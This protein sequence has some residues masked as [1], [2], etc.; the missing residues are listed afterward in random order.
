MSEY[1]LSNFFSVGALIP[2]FLFLFLFAF[3]L[4]IR[5]KSKSTFHLTFSYVWAILFNLGYFISG[6]F[7]HPDAAFHRWLTVGAILF[8]ETH[9]NMF[10]FNLCEEKYHR[11]GRALLIAQY[12]VAACA[13]AAFYANTI[14]ADKIFLFEG[15][16]WDFR[17]DEISKFFGVM[18]QLYILIFIAI[19]VWKMI[20][21]RGRD[22]FFIALIAATYLLTSIVPSTVNVLSRDGALNRE[23]FQI[24]WDLFNVIGFSLLAILYIN[25][26]KDRTTFMAK[27]IGIS[28]LTLLILL[29]AL[30]YYSFQENES[31]YDEIHRSYTELTI[32][33]NRYFPDTNYLVLYNEEKN[34][35]NRLYWTRNEISSNEFHKYKNEYL[36]TLMWHRIMNLPGENF[37]SNLERLLGVAHYH[38]AGYRKSMLSSAPG[39]PPG[40]IRIAENL[41]RGIESLKRVILYESNK[42]RKMPDER[43]RETLVKHIAN[44]GGAIAPFREA[45]AA[46]LSRSASNGFELKQEVLEFLAPMLPPDARRYRQN[47]DSSFQ[48]TAYLKV[49]NDRSVYE[50]G[51]SYKYYRDFLHKSAKRY[52]VI[53]IAMFIAVLLGYPLFFY[54]NLIRPLMTLRRGVEQIR[55]GDLDINI[56]VGVEDE[57]GFLTHNFNTMAE[58][59]KNAK[60][61]IDEYTLLLE[62][63]V[64]ERTIELEQAMKNLS[65]MNVQL[66]QAR[67]AL[68]GEMELAKKIQTILLPEKPKIQ[69]CDVLGYMNPADEVG[70]DYYD[71]LNF[72]AADWIIIGDVSG[73]GVPSG[74]IMMMVQS[75]IQSILRSDPDIMPALL[76]A[77]INMSI[78]YNIKK[79]GEKKFMTICAFKFLKDGTIIYA[80][81]H[82]DIL[83]YRASM[84]K[85]ESVKT[86]GMWIGLKENIHEFLKNESFTLHR[87]DVILLY[88]DGIIE[89]MDESSKKRFSVNKLIEIMEDAGTLSPGDMKNRILDELKRFRISDDI[90]M[91]IIKK[92]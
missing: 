69:G 92:L 60:Q 81:E 32:A 79:L 25:Y 45:I 3:F 78:T 56:P 4:I 43:F 89:A 30:T 18:I 36:N 76:L 13:V 84:K 7:Y 16:Y 15:H 19:A 59:I 67:D 50:I 35:I 62:E 49:L 47:S 39:I 34:A 68:W 61:E 74:L 22:R 46:H 85:V 71:V 90:A 20:T 44:G 5:N 37:R 23:T 21:L 55:T 87:D 53:I 82:L 77:I 51:Y 11:A 73:H 64:K 38:F 91:V 33:E 9:N 54:Y 83:I 28:L 26:M 63:K 14:N 1:F 70:G 42:I 6:S 24:T 57:I 86:S 40:D 31:S 48:C 65:S 10:L 12:A 27:I 41:L 29:Q 80:G 52:L 72:T 75:A 88:T 58:T 8:W 66:M 2:T 17:A